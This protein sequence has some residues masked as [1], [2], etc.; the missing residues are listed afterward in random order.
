MSG[1][2][3]V[4]HTDGTPVAEGLVARLMRATEGRG[5]DGRRSWVLGPVGLGH[6]LLATSFTSNR[7]V[8][9]L[10]LGTTW[11]VADARLDARSELMA[12]LS[13]QLPRTQ[14]DKEVQESE[15]ATD[16]EL[17]LCA[18]RMWGEHCVEHLLGDFCFAIWDASLGRLFCARDHFGVK[19]FYYAHKHHVFVFGNTLNSLRLHPAVSNDLNELAVADF[20]LFELNQDPT[21]T[22]FADMR[23]LA[24]AHTLTLSAGADP[25]TH[26]YWTLSIGAQHSYPRP[27]D[28]VDRFTE[29]FHVSVRDRLR[30]DRA[31]LLMSGGLDSSSIA[32]SAKRCAKPL[33]LR[34][35]TMVY[36]RLM[37]DQ[38][39]HY[40]GLTA[41]FLGVPIHFLSVDDYSLFDRWERPDLIRPEPTP[42]ALEAME[43]DFFA[44]AASS[45]RVALSGDGGDALQCPPQGQLL[46]LLKQGHLATLMRGAAH[47]WRTTGRWPRIGLRYTARQMTLGTKPRGLPYPAW[48]NPDLER[49]LD[50]RLRWRQAQHPSSHE[51]AGCPRPEAY[52]FLAQPYWA[53]WFEMQDPGATGEALEIR[54]PF[55]DRRLVEFMLGVPAIPWCVEKNLLRVAMEGL[56][57]DE[58][59]LRPKTPLVSDG[60]RERQDQAT[61]W[62][63][64]V[65]PAADLARFVDPTRISGGQAAREPL[66]LR[67]R[68][69]S[70]DWWLRHFRALTN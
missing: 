34:A 38:E 35:H 20:L 54:Y 21:T 65:A 4:F 42:G 57:P 22:T 26:R 43:R 66:W 23:R 61:G 60:L 8:Q 16:A 31:A 56:L 41:E 48:I 30:T 6:A 39:R 52:N 15:A 67:L 53:F 14:G 70:L 68:V 51:N 46:S 12:R 32:A 36:D 29:L 28:Y 40:A 13:R 50:L 45:A 24:P 11:I 55:F 58:V 47:L 1:I 49:R 7:D 59:R 37:P 33:A 63:T 10:R 5:P 9:P 64:R 17:I 69:I 19:P 25:V 62:W 2:V 27:H 18:Y 3:G 44:A